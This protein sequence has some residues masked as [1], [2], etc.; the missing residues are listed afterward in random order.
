MHTN[1]DISMFTCVYVFTYT[2]RHNLGNPES[3]L[4]RTQQRATFHESCSE[5]TAA[6]RGGGN[7]QTSEA[8]VLNV[9]DTWLSVYWLTFTAVSRLGSKCNVK[10]ITVTTEAIKHQV[11]HSLCFKTGEKTL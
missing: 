5:P 3:E 9:Q 4:H 2:Y 11:L 8:Q 7:P 10:A 1:K 6:M